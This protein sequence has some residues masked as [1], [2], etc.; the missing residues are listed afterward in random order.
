MEHYP[1][2]A[3]CQTLKHTEKKATEALREAVTRT[4]THKVIYKRYY[5]MQLHG[6]SAAMKAFGPSILHNLTDAEILSEFLNAWLEC[7]KR[8]RI[9]RKQAKIDDYHRRAMLREWVTRREQAKE[10]AQLRREQDTKSPNEEIDARVFK[11]PPVSQKPNKGMVTNYLQAWPSPR[12]S[13]HYDLRVYSVLRSAAQSIGA[14][15]ILPLIEERDMSRMSGV[16]G[17]S[18]RLDIYDDPTDASLNDSSDGEMNEAVT[19][20]C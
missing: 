8:C 14:A 13:P 2:L 15:R 1:C 5:N 12:R 16:T 9:R 3:A 4:A 17:G 18:P 20:L 6:N 19:L 11:L 7:A 10:R